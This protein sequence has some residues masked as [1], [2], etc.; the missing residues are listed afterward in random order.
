MKLNFPK[1]YRLLICSALL[2]FSLA[3]AILLSRGNNPLYLAVVGPMTGEAQLE[4]QEMLQG[5]NLYLDQVNQEGGIGGKQVKLLEFDDQRD[6]I[7][8]RQKA[9]EIA[10][11][12]K[13]LVVLGHSSSSTSVEGSKVYQKNGIPAI[14]GSATDLAVTEGNDRYFRVIVDN[15]SEGIFLANYVKRILH[16]KS[17]SI[18]YQ[19][20]EIA[21]K[22]I[23]NAFE[24]AFRGLGG[25][26]KYKWV[27]DPKSENAE[28]S[29]NQIILDLSRAKA[30]RVGVVFLATTSNETAKLLPKMKRRGLEYPL[31]GS[32][33]LDEG[34]IELIKQYPEEQSIPGYFSD[35]IY[36]TSHI[37]FDTSGEKAQQFRNKYL[38]K[39]HQEPSA[40][41]ATY[42]DA[43]LIAIQGMKEAEV[44]GERKNLKDERQK[45]KDALAKINEIED[46]TEGV[47]G[48][49]YFDQQGNAIKEIDVGVFQEQRLISSWTQLSPVTDLKK[50]AA[51]DQELETGDVLLVNGQYMQKT[52][53]VYTG[54]DLNEV[55]DLD[56]KNSTY[57]LDF[58]L[59]FRSKS[60]IKFDE[61]EFINAAEP[62]KLGQPIDEKISDNGITYRL[63]RIKAKFKS[64]FAFHEYP[65]DTQNLE[66]KFR[67]SYLNREDLLYVQDLVG[68]RNQTNQAILS[69]FE[70]SQ[71][72]S[73][74]PNWKVK[75]ASF[76]VDIIK[77]SSTLGNPQFFNSDIDI[78]YSR[79]NAIIKIQRDGISFAFK[80]LLPLFLIICVS[81][82]LFFIPPEQISP[83]VSIGVSTLLTTAFFHQRLSS[84]LPEIGYIIA[85]EY[86]FY[87]VYLLALLGLAITITCYIESKI[88]NQ[89]LVKFLTKVVKGVY[90]SLVF[91]VG[92]LFVSRYVIIPALS[93]HDN[94]G[95]SLSPQKS[96]VTDATLGKAT[97]EQVTLTLS[98]WR[99]DDVEQINRILAV[100]KTKHPHINIKFIPI[101]GREYNSILSS[102]LEKGVASDLFYLGSFSISEFLFRDGYLELLED[103]PGLKDNFTPENL[104]PWASD[105]GKSYGVPFMAVSHGIYYNVELFKKLNLK[106]PTTW[107]DLLRSAQ[108]IKDAGY[109]P[110]A[111]GSKDKWAVSEIVFMNLAPNFIGGREGRLKYISGER[112]FNDEHAV[113][114][115]QA[116]ADITPFLPEGQAKLGYYESQQLFMQGKAA[117]WMG[118]S[119][120]IPILES[121]AP[122]LTWSVFA[123]PA[124][125]GKPSH[126]T[127]HPDFAIGLN[128]VSEHKQEAKLFLQW[129]TTPEAAELFSNE[130]PG[131]FPMHKTVPEIRNQHANTFLKLNK[132]RG[133]DA[134]WAYPKLRDGVPDG[135]SLMQNGTVRVING[136]MT[137]QTAADKL[138]NGLAQWFE[139]A[140]ICTSA[141]WIKGEDFEIT[142]NELLDTRIK[143]WLKDSQVIEAIKAQNTKFVDISPD[144]IKKLD[145]TWQEEFKS[146]NHSLIDSVLEKPLSKYLKSI[147]EESYGLYTEITVMDSRGLNVALSDKNTDYWQGDEPK[148]Q[149]TYQIGPDAIHISELEFDQSTS[150]W[151]IQLSLP[152]LNPKTQQLIGAVT[153]GIDP[154]QLNIRFPLD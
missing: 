53:V 80:N 110:F 87:A 79:F 108:V 74:I 59:W 141:D 62:I 15:V 38:E 94:K 17:A 132:G 111:N 142:I 154:E 71:V 90:P 77:D 25:T 30:D 127:L 137:P 22:S 69:K 82:L 146:G 33:S 116:V 136:E 42:Y 125:A 18:V 11:Q 41:A 58:Y 115:F 128:A 86:I 143:P 5:I 21:S 16:Q 70:R 85:I 78:E 27:V 119:W 40:I 35:D 133:N 109:I 88:G 122:N 126:I 47:T 150:K 147:K 65:F 44:Q 83:R 97:D 9:W 36:A 149:E 113:A 84:D 76:Y 103:L 73:S 39:Y 63:Y 43:T 135:Y 152:I 92:F 104:A 89:K 105:D 151:Q 153:I 117:M 124:P 56:Q 144:Q 91:T 12:K 134:R 46:A 72:F 68:M 45:I 121:E 7:L 98:S 131:F 1:K 139:P 49:I 10:Q 123:V 129:L 48:P 81:Y 31:I 24:D 19:A 93:A 120:D 60:K 96:L 112:C 106:V 20:D 145:Q 75:N 140:R 101:D 23:A 32:H 29:R 34:F 55:S 130:L 64:N 3:I 107:E 8:A 50:I 54:V 4:G 57:T 114:A 138:Q 61:I 66:I 99:T 6:P 13:A 118:G 51:L 37:I 14:T 2:I 100:F 28:K 102:Q 67:H 52:Q 26:V 95:L 148:Y